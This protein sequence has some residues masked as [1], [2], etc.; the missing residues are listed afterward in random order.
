VELTGGRQRGLTLETE[1]GLS[2]AHYAAP[3]N[4]TPR[5]IT[6]TDA[7]REAHAAFISQIKE[8]VWFKE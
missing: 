4:R 1:A 6:L 3:V 5:R 8:P 7:Q 2:F